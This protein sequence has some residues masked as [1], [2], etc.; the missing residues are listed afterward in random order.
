MATVEQRISSLEG[1]Y[2]HLA[3]KSDLAELRAD[4]YKVAVQLGLFI[5]GVVGVGVAFLKFTS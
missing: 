1:T 5:T 2:E 3:T 4:I